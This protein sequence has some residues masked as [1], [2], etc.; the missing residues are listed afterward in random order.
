M[1]RYRG[2][3]G[4]KAVSVLLALI[5]WLFVFGQQPNTDVPEFTRTITNVPI[6]TLGAD[7]DS[8]YLITPAT[9]DIVI[10]GSQ[11]FI[12]TMI[13]REHT[14]T[15]DVRD[16]GEGIHNLQVSASMTGGVLQSILPN[17]VTV[18]IDV[19]A[20][21]QFDVTV[22]TIGTLP[23]GM[24]IRDITV[25]PK[26]IS[27]TGPNSE[28]ERV[29][30][31]LATLNLDEL[32]SSGEVSTTV[33]VLDNHKRNVNS[34]QLN[35]SSVIIEVELEQEVLETTLAVKHINL[36]EGFNVEITRPTVQVKYPSTITIEDIQLYL[37]LEG[38]TAGTHTV[39]IEF[40]G[41]ELEGIVIE[42][43]QIEVII[44]EGE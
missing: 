35:Q 7:R 16:L 33:S 6:E 24:I 17:Y 15:V 23:E 44:E 4:T 30:Q 42:P 41:Q 12:N 34:L 27:I 8:Q 11:E 3:I 1:R 20:T 5:L 21:N 31:V 29:S 18:V 25:N 13:G 39:D 28:L 36:A 14:V 32:T 40:N 37:D 10:R 19:I 26:S 43:S 38:L 9:V 2:N 22:E